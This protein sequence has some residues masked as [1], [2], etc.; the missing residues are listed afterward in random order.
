MTTQAQVKTRGQRLIDS[1]VQDGLIGPE[2]GERMQTELAA[3]GSRYAAATD[4]LRQQGLARE[5]VNALGARVPE[6]EA[7]PAL[8]TARLTS[9][10]TPTTPTS[11]TAATQGAPVAGGTT[12]SGTPSQRIAAA[13]RA[14]DTAWRPV[15]R[16]TTRAE[17]ESQSESEGGLSNAGLVGGVVIC[18]VAIGWFVLGLKIGRIY[19]Y[20]PLLL[21]MGIVSIARGLRDALN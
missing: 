11:G 21:L 6:E 3:R 7:P 15:R 20:P 14:G 17:S 1:A 19:Y 12:T 10:I 9:A 16:A 4:L 5:V 13:T 2:D 8:A 18:A